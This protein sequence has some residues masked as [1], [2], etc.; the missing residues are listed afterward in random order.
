MSETVT[1]TPRPWT[2]LYDGACRFCTAGQ[3]RLVRMARPGAVRAL[4]FR[5]AGV[6][7]RFPAVDPADA[8]RALQLVGPDGRVY[9]GADAVFRALA[10]RPMYRPLLWLRAIPG[11]RQL[12]DGAYA[13]IARNRFRIAGRT[14]ATPA[15]A[16][17]DCS[18]GTCRIGPF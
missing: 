17:P 18:T 14:A 10:T 7:A 13:L 8:E 6:L 12:I 4:S 16:G 3:A 5:D 9:R 11:L 2:L 15:A 1:P